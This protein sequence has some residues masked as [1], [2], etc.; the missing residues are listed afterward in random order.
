MVY[1]PASEEDHESVPALEQFWQRLHRS[2]PELGGGI[3]VIETANPRT[4]YDLTRRKLGMV[5]GVNKVLDVESHQTTI[6]NL[7]MVGD[8]VCPLKGITSV[9]QSA[10]TLANLLTK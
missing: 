6:P 10:L 9:T 4:F 1:L 7:F 3:E 8:T 5:M 2:V